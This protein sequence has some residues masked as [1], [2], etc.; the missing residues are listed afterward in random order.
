[1]TRAPLFA[2]IDD[3]IG[4]ASSGDAGCQFHQLH[5]LL[6]DLGLPMN[7]NK[8]TPPCKVLT[9]LGIQIDIKNSTLSIEP[10]K[11]T[12]IHQECIHIASKKFI[13]KKTFQ[14]LLGKLI[15]IH[16]CVV[17]SRIFINR[18]LDLFR[19]VIH[20]KKIKLTKEFF[21]DLAWF[22]AFL[23]SFNGVTSYDR[24]TLDPT[25]AI[26]L[27]ACLSGIGGLW[28]DR[29]YSLHLLLLSLGLSLPLFTSR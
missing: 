1:M 27:D 20:K 10:T 17:P 11:L 29:E 25:K 13:S 5:A 3:Y 24:P 9:Y 7:S 15:Y 28:S 2:Y 18:M 23:P 12:S 8:I 22:Q 4:V 14:S 19:K 16:K 21:Q 6:T 26:Y